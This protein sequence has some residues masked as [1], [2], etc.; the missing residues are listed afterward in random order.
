[1]KNFRKVLAL[2]L[3][4]ATLFSFTAMA[5]AVNIGEYEDW[6]KVSYAEAVDVLSAV[7][8]LN[9]Y[10][11]D[12]FKPTNTISREEMAKMIAVLANSGED[13]STLYA[14][15][16][17]FADVATTKWSA[18]YVAYCAK[19]GIVA[20]RSAT[21]FDPAGKV[22]GLETA[23]ML[24]VVL[25]FDAEEQGY[26]GADWKVNVL[27]DAKTMSLLDGFAADYDVDAAI[28]REEAAQMMMNALLAPCVVGVLS[29]GIVTVTNALIASW[30]W[31]AGISEL[32][33]IS[34]RGTLKDAIKAGKWCL[35]GNVVI[36]NDLL[37]DTL[38][39]GLKKSTDRKSVV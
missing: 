5:G 35:Y 15:A 7:G 34:V 24:L 2:V 25:G 19:T 27:R 21:T 23:K 30:N 26:V 9:G 22:T 12:T 31:K 17:T 39:K 36:S 14:S 32:F 29:D 1:M 11:D 8:I 28:T 3:V 13:V 6:S 38:F 33:D 37:V 16:C 4:V 10:E 18:S 20:G